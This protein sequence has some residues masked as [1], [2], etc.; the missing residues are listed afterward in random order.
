[1]YILSNHLYKTDIFLAKPFAIKNIPRDFYHYKTTLMD[2]LEEHYM[3]TQ[4][5]SQVN[6]FV[7]YNMHISIRFSKPTP[8]I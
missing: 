1:M 6:L 8:Y 4:I 7:R 2:I 3:H 5:R